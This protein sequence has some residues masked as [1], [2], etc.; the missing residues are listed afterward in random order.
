MLRKKVK[1]VPRIVYPRCSRCE[2][3][4][5][6]FKYALSSIFNRNLEYEVGEALLVTL[7]YLEMCQHIIKPIQNINTDEGSGSNE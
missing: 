2:E 5:D 6:K 4:R 3:G 7:S 1:R